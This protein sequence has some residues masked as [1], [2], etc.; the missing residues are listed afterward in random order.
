MKINPLLLIVFK[1]SKYFLWLS[2]AISLTLGVIIFVY[3]MYAQSVPNGKFYNQNLRDHLT[4]K[5]DESDVAHIQAKYPNDAYFALGYL[6]ARERTWQMEFNRRLASGTLSEVLGDKTVDID[7]F[8]KTL[9][10]RKAA[11]LQYEN[12]PS[13]TK[14]AIESYSNGVNAG[15]QD[16][17]WALPL[18]F[19]LTGSKPALWTPI[20]TVSWS[21]MMALDLGDNWNKEFTRLALAKDLPTSKIWEIIP[22]YEGDSPA[23]SLDF[24]KMYH[25]ADIY[26]KPTTQQSQ[27]THLDNLQAF[28]PQNVDGKGS[29]NWVISGSHTASK[30]PL[31]ANDPHLGLS[32]PSTWY[33]AHLDAK[34]LNVIG[35]T[36]PGLPGVVLGYTPKLAWGFTNTAPDVQDLFI[37]AIHPDNSLQY[38]TPTGYES[39]KVRREIIFVKDQE[40]IN[41]VVRET[42]HGPVISDAYPQ[43]A[44]IIDTKR[45]VL[46]LQWAALDPQNQ[47][48]Q[49]LIDMN[50]AQS[51]ESLR[52]SLE[53]Y[54]APMQ[55][56]VMADTEGKIAYTVAGVAPKRLK[57]QGMVGV[58]PTF[59]WDANNDWKEFVKPSELPHQYSPE[60]PWIFTANQKVEDP[61][62][63]NTLTADW[64]MPYRANR[65][66]ELLEKNKVHD[67]NTM[68][69]LQNDT[70]SLAAQP[71]L[72]LFKKSLSSSSHKN[73]LPKDI[74]EFKGDMKI[75]S[76]NALIFNTWVDQL[77]RAI[78][79]EKLGDSF[80]RLYSQRGLRDGLLSVVKNNPQYWCKSSPASQ[81]ND[82]SELSNLA[83]ENALNYLIKRYGKNMNQWKWGDAHIATGSH[84]PFGQVPFL[85]NIFNLKISSPGDGQTINVGTMSFNDKT[86]P[87]SSKVAP[88]MRAIYDLSN[89]NE[90]I[91][92]GFG[93]QSGWVQS[94]RY[95]EYIDD[96]SNGNYLPLNMAPKEFRS[97]QLELSP[98]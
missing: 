36:I 60:K 7:R 51:L 73:E 16:L 47:S 84:K 50:K 53:K 15:Y 1:A 92:I 93:G 41:F 21:L 76:P 48:M 94:R 96:W 19:W 79:T 83:L 65:I 8:I 39:F 42:R 9:G 70:Y 49:A 75:D 33:F 88:G 46:S 55:N 12:L 68:K 44:K 6:H 52:D 97:Y 78:F 37:E 31:L 61:L 89:L 82:C 26:L 10:I 18:E 5:F 74:Y 4:I 67:I 57:N 77:T 29:N 85:R 24:A 80:D 58:A 3:S 43:A 34:D 98:N 56:V 14:L 35:G 69:S 95:K 66:S 22:P 27:N 11:R 63:P 71:L 87:Y 28:L 64:T 81:I 40:P 91:F 23:T 54:Y 30:K 72:E 20:D 90:S 38:K 13:S 62:A 86:E 45:F 25:D 17:G 32:S 59:G 2:I